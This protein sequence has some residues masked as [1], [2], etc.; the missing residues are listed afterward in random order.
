M[1]KDWDYHQLS[2]HIHKNMSVYDVMC[3]VLLDQICLVKFPHV[4]SIA[5]PRIHIQSTFSGIPGKYDHVIKV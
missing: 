4:I 2:H 5:G 1:R 3:P